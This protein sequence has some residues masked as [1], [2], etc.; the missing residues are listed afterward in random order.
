MN[1]YNIICDRQ[2]L[3]TTKCPLI[4]EKGTAIHPYHE[5]LLKQ[6]KG[7]D[8]KFPPPVIKSKGSPLGEKMAAIHITKC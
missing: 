3:E 5:I 2:K 6:L 4:G 1:A 7:F 8:G